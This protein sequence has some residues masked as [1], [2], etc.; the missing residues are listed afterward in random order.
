VGILLATADRL[1]V[2]RAQVAALE[3]QLAAETPQLGLFES[4]GG[5]KEKGTIL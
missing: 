2:A 5:V 1:A 3:R 4:R